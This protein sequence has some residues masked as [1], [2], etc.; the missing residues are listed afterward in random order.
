MAVVVTKYNDPWL[1]AV[2][3]LIQKT[4]SGDIL[5]SPVG[6]HRTRL[7]GEPYVAQVCGKTVLIYEQLHANNTLFQQTHVV[8]EFVDPDHGWVTQWEWPGYEESLQLL[9]V[10][11]SN[12]SGGDA[13]LAEFLGTKDT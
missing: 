13:F 11:R 1:Q 12:V 4:R 7:R 9:D 2:E 6:V 5:W 8:L 10:I 3:K